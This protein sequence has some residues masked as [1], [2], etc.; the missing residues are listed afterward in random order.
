MSAPVDDSQGGEP[1]QDSTPLRS[2]TEGVTGFGVD[3]PGAILQL[4]AAAII[5]IVTGFIVAFTVFR[6]NEALGAVFLF[7]MPIGGFLILAVATSLYWS[8][9]TRQT[10]GD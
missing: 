10:Q 5:T 7:G 9:K 2:E 6:T 3:Q 1:D 4:V 8:S